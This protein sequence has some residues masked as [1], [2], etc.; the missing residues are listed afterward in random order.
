MNR[1]VN[2]GGRYYVETKKYLLGIIPFWVKVREN[3]TA[4]YDRVMF[5]Y[6]WSDAKNHLRYLNRT[7]Q[8]S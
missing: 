3:T 2:E 6:D 4:T 5:F 7:N 8:Q 1:I